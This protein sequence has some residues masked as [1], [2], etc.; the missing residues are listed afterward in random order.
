MLTAKGKAKDEQLGKDCG[1]DVYLT[2]P[3]RIQ[4]L[5]EQIRPLL[6]APRP[7]DGTALA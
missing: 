5:L 4:P 3:F 1:A 2:K 7:S 6:G